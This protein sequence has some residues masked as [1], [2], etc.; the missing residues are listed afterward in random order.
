MKRLWPGIIIVI[1]FMI[2]NGCV[3]VTT[4]ETAKNFIAYNKQNAWMGPKFSYAKYY[5]DS[6]VVFLSTPLSQGLKMQNTIVGFEI[7]GDDKTFYSAEGIQHKDY[8]VLK[9]PNVHKPIAVRY[10][11]GDNPKCNLYTIEGLPASPFRT[12]EW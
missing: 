6:V 9:H 8:V 7:A 10:G 11:W 12:D 3:S 1:S 5:N 4:V 2:L